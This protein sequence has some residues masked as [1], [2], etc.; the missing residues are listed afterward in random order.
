MRVEKKSAALIYASYSECAVCPRKSERTKGKEILRSAYQ[1]TMD[2]V[3]ERTKANEAE[4][5]K[6]SQIVEHAF[7][8]V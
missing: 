2:V 3:T 7:G 6:R 1:D 5:K 4:Y 8:T